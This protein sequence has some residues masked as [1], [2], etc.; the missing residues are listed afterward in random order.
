MVA[1][2]ELI[3]VSNT[4]QSDMAKRYARCIENGK[5]YEVHR[6][7]HHLGQDTLFYVVNDLGGIHLLL[8]DQ[9]V[10]RA[11]Q[12]V[13]A[14]QAALAVIQDLRVHLDPQQVHLA[15]RA[16]LHHRQALAPAAGERLMPLLIA[17]L[18]MFQILESIRIVLPPKTLEKAIKRTQVTIKIVELRK[19]QD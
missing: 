7:I 3:L 11:D 13:V 6:V 9:R 10:H 5:I 8:A 12:T 16:A 19:M 4:G 17:I 15:R 14:I 2:V 18:V 1:L